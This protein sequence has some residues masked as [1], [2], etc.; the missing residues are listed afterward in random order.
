MAIKGGMRLLFQLILKSDIYKT[1]KHVEFS[2]NEDGVEGRYL[3]HHFLCLNIKK[4]TY[5]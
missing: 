5:S 4:I 2:D 1:E 3:L